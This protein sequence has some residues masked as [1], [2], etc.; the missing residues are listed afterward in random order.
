MQIKDVTKC[1]FLLEGQRDI[2][3]YI[4]TKLYNKRDDFNFSLL[5]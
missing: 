5:M 2:A 4:T 3:G 1:N